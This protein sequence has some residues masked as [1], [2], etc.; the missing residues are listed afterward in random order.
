MKTYHYIF[1]DGY[2]CWTTG[3]MDKTSFKWE[4][5]RHGKLVKVEQEG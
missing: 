5:V 4:V 1:K 2:E 3:K